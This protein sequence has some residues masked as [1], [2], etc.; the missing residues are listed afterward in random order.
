[1]KIKK[2]AFVTSAFVILIGTIGAAALYWYPNYWK[3]VVGLDSLSNE[4][5]RAV[6]LMAGAAVPAKGGGW[7]PRALM[8]RTLG[9]NAPASGVHWIEGR[10]V[11]GSL[12][13]S[14]TASEGDRAA[15]ACIFRKRCSGCHGGDGSGGLHGPS[16]NRSGYKHGDSDLAIY[17]ILRDGVPGTA[18]PSA[19]LPPRELLQV[20][21]HVRTLQVHQS[22]DLKAEGSAWLST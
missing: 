5:I 22:I 16:L 2:L 19:D 7:C 21:A 6:V 1:M 11:K 17:K 18:M 10:S 20:V 15:G 12:V 9:A 13:Y 8:D 4:K 3:S 14:A